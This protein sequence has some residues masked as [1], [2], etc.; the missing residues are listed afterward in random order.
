MSDPVGDWPPFHRGQFVDGE[1]PLDGEEF[2]AWLGAV[3]SVRA[4]RAL[5]EPRDCGTV[6]L[7]AI[8]CAAAGA[9]LAWWW[10]RG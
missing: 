9:A 3:R 6:D 4:P 1:P 5:P 10:L 2:D 8:A 7:T